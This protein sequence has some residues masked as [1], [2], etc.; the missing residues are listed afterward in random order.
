MG[1]RSSLALAPSA[2]T[3]YQKRIS[4]P[5]LDRNDFHVKVRCVDYQKLSDDRLGEP[6]GTIRGGVERARAM[7]F[8]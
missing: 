1:I 6:S 8:E 3:E 2:V 5:L 4:G 7:Q